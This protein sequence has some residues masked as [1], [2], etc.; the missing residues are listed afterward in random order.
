MSKKEKQEI[1]PCINNWSFKAFI[2]NSI[3]QNC[4][5]YN[6]ELKGIIGVSKT[7]PDSKKYLQT[8][9]A[10]YHEMIIKNCHNLGKGWGILDCN[11]SQIDAF[12]EKFATPLIQEFTKGGCFDEIYK[13]S[14]EFA[15]CLAI[16]IALT[17]KLEELQAEPNRTPKNLLHIHT[18]DDAQKEELFDTLKKLLKDQKGKRVAL[19]IHALQ[20]KGY[21]EHIDR[22]I[23]DI[24]NYFSREFNIT[25][26][27]EAIRQQY[28]KEID[29]MREEVIKDIEKKLP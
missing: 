1:P 22:N 16:I 21:I 2:K 4:K 15:K 24:F 17:A 11:I 9:I 13:E 26:S 28:L 19:V 25:G 7:H 8:K 10:E 29:P 12:C 14:E 6:I 23:T 18:K 27:A 20:R 5:T 3:K